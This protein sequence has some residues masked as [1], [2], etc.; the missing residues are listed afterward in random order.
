L[1][2][3]SNAALVPGRTPAR[4][5]G[6]WRMWRRRGRRHV[7]TQHRPLPQQH[8]LQSRHVHVLDDRTVPPL[9]LQSHRRR[10]ARGLSG[11][12]V[13]R[14]QAESA[15]RDPTGRHAHRN[16][17]VRAVRPSRNQALERD[18]EYPVAAWNLVSRLHLTRVDLPE[19]LH[20]GVAVIP[21]SGRDRSAGGTVTVDC[22]TMSGVAAGR[23]WWRERHAV[24]EVEVDEP[25]AQADGRGLPA[26]MGRTDL[27]G[28][29]FPPS[30]F[31]S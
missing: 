31:I 24:Y 20:Q 12:H 23:W 22:A 21:H 19:I 3:G 4:P 5:C 11:D 15:E 16:Q 2:W 27:P 17:Q 14:L 28:Q 26:L 29:C 1:H 9:L 8:H 25:R 6:V 13:L 18:L 7:R 10:R 30:I